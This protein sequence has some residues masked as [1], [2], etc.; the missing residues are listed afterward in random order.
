MSNDYNKHYNNGQ[1]VVVNGDNE[2][3]TEIDDDLPEDREQ[4]NAQDLTGRVQ[5]GEAKII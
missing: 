1:L 3:Y 5:K 2:H 4:I